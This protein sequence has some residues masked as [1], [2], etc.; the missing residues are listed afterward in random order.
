MIPLM[1]ARSPRGRMIPTAPQIKFTS[2]YLYKFYL[3]LIRGVIDWS[4]AGSLCDDWPGWDADGSLDEN[5]KAKIII[6]QS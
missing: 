3:Y 5:T 1:I 6:P 4:V 2:S